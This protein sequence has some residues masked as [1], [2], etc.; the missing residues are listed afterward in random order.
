MK[1]IKNSFL[2]LIT[3]AASVN[4]SAQFPVSFGVKAGMNLSEIQK[5]EDD[6]KVGFNIGLTAELALPSSFYLLSGVEF[7]TKGAKSGSLISGVDSKATYNAMYLQLPIHAGYKFDLVPGTKLFVHLGPYLAYGVG[8]K[9]KWDAKEIENTDFF[10]DD[11]NR[12]DF[13]ISGAVGVE[14][15]NKINVSL[16]A[17]QGLTKVIKDTK[18][19]NRAA[20]ISVGY[21]F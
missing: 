12:F 4:V 3:L 18:T 16:G 15:L 17:D 14:F 7:T 8:G 20:Y 21:K 5:M 1:I 6:I 10:N 9:I 11:S 19:K 13:G 2:L